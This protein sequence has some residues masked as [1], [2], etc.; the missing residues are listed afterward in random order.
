MVNR[1]TKF[2]VSTFTGNELNED[3]KANAKCK[4]SRFEPPFGG[5]TPDLGVTHMVY[6]RLDGKRIVDFLLVIIALFPLAF[7]AE[8]LLS[9]ICRNRHFRK[10]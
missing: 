3:M 6:L 4:N 8:A 10:G 5:L 1:H 9:Y 7:K 2:E